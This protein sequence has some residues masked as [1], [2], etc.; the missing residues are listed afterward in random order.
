MKLPKPEFYYSVGLL[1][2]DA[3]LV[4]ALL[5]MVLGVEDNAMIAY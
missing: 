4:R 3:G 5:Q 2:E 1:G